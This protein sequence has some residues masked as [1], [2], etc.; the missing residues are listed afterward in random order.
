MY[1]TIYIKPTIRNCPGFSL[2]FDKIKL[3]TRCLI[4]ILHRLYILVLYL[5]EF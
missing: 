3:K 2:D 4:N 5:I 1:I